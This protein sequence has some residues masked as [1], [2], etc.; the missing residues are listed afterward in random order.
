VEG[1]GERAELAGRLGIEEKA[2]QIEKNA[3]IIN[4]FCDKLWFPQSV[5]PGLVF[6]VKIETKGNF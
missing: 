6:L 1:R 4:G 2:L 5:T 3:F